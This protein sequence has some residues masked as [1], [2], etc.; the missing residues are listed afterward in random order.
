MQIN[1]INQTCQ[2]S[3]KSR[4]FLN[5]KQVGCMLQI[6]ANLSSLK[7]KLTLLLLLILGV[8]WASGYAIAGFV[9]RHGVSPNGYAFW[10][11]FGPFVC[12]L[13]VQLVRRDVRITF[14]AIKYS[15]VTGLVALAIPNLLVY[16]AAKTVDSSILTV[17][18]NTDPI[19]TYVLALLLGQEIFR[20]NRLL[21]VLIGCTGILII[22]YPHGQINN[23]DSN[24]WL[25]LSLLI[26]FCYAFGI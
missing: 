5:L 21:F 17:L 20:K 24:K 1:R 7:L 25:Y 14:S 23:L 9:M 10:Q 8:D 18:A 22:V 16:Y 13:L 11:S 19:F 26:P 15:L 3:I 6:Q 4:D 2:L 12:L